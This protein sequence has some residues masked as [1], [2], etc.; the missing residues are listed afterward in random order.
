MENK[1]YQIIF[2]ANASVEEITDSIADVFSVAY[3]IEKQLADGFQL[4]DLLVALQV[5]STIREVVNDFP[6]FV[7]EFQQLSGSTALQAVEGAKARSVAEFGNLG[8]VGTFIYDFLI[9]SARTFNFIE[10]TVVQGIGQLNQ[11]KALFASVKK[12]VE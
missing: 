5:E 1:E 10:A 8:K 6:I 4:T 12:P 7:Q 3:K 11:W 2:S 9:Q